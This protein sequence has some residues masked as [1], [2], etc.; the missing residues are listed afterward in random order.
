MSALSP[1]RSLISTSMS[2]SMMRGM[3]SGGVQR[4]VKM[5]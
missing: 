3:A 1:K 5:I 4:G 2:S